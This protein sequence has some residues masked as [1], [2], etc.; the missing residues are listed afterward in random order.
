MIKSPYDIFNADTHNILSG[1]T[2]ETGEETLRAPIDN[3]GQ[4]Q[5][6]TFNPQT[7]VELTVKVAPGAIHIERQNGESFG[8]ADYSSDQ[9]NPVSA[10]RRAVGSITLIQD[11]DGWA[12]GQDPDGLVEVESS[13]SFGLFWRIVAQQVQK[14]RAKRAAASQTI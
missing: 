8:I 12:V 10:L 13:E 7:F 1:I 11:K 5:L 4:V 6:L 9:F 14:A 3:Q 2:T